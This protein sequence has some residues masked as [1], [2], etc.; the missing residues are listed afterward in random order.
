MVTRVSIVLLRT[1]RYVVVN[2]SESTSLAFAEQVKLVVV[3]PDVGD[4]VGEAVGAVL[5]IVMV[6]DVAGVPDV[7]P[8][9]G[10]TTQ[11]TRSPLLKAEPV[12][13]VPVTLM[14]RPFTNHA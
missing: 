3:V 14:F 5:L 4:I 2:R 6:F 1:H 9:F 8:S 7:M 12:N 13:E 10:V 11:Y